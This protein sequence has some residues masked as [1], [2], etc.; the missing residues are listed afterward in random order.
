MS[1]NV[2]LIQQ[3][4]LCLSVITVDFTKRLPR[5]SKLRSEVHKIRF[6]VHKFNIQ[7]HKPVCKQDLWLVHELKEANQILSLQTSFWT[8]ELGNFKLWNFEMNLQTLKQ[9]SEHFGKSYVK[10]TVITFN[11]QILNFFFNSTSVESQLGSQVSFIFGAFKDYII[12]FLAYYDASNRRSTMVINT[13]PS[14]KDRNE[15]NPGAFR[16]G[17]SI[18]YN[19]CLHETGTK[20]TQTGLKS[21]RLLD[22][23]DWLQTGMNS[24]RDECKHKYISD[25]SRL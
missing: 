15:V 16:F 23:A 3:S 11:V 9:S 17:H 4:V 25:R 1:N 18:I 10:S 20:I 12:L 19:R 6:E 5:R 13:M 22:R 7:I 8:Y 14:Y 2:C 24:D 21:F